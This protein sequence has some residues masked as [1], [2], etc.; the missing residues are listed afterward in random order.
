MTKVPKDMLCP[1]IFRVHLFR[2]KL[3][4]LTFVFYLKE[5]ESR[6]KTLSVSHFVIL[7][8]VR[9]EKRM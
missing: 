5:G 7:P 3:K 9:D 6:M 8:G 2:V 1:T 4:F